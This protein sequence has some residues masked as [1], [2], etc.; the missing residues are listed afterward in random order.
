[1]IRLDEI[2]KS[3]AARYMGVRG[4]IDSRTAYLLEKYEPA[5]RAALRPAY[6]YREAEISR[7]NGEIQILGIN[8]TGESI[9][10]HL[11]GCQR[12]VIFAATVSAAADTLIRQTSV[13]DAAGALAVDCLC[14][15]AVEQVCGKVEDE[16]FSDIN[17]V[18]RTWR[19]S[20]GYGDLPIQ[21]QREF[22]AALNAQRRIGLTVTESCM[23]LP[24]KSVTAVIGI[25]D[26][27]VS[28]EQIS[29][30][31]CPARENCGIRAAG[32]CQRS[33]L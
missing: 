25:S 11:K 18:Y 24:A 6:V 26:I 13:S 32:G 22:L 28:P 17:A 15:S 14:S 1:M 31:V 16:I 23:L 19:F 27:P 4:E 30:D 3:E 8:M 10:N 2:S 9:K 7:N 21:L 12:A 29:C 5:V 20:P 33:S